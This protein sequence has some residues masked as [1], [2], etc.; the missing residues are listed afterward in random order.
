MRLGEVSTQRRR[1]PLTPLIDIVFL[2][3][4]FFMLASTFLK[5]DVV[6]LARAGAGS[7]QVDR[8]K[9]MLIHVSRDSEIAVNGATTSK[10]QLVETV[11]RA[12]DA[13][14]V[15]AIV[16]LRSDTRVADLVQTLDLIRRSRAATVRIVD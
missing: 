10:D 5:F 13:G 1:I 12:V 8:S 9:I 14:Q 15:H 7:G 4:V 2:L 6:T 11:N 3:L 16:V